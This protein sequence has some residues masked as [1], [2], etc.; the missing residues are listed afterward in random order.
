MTYFF[1][2]TPKTSGTTF[3][4]VLASDKNNRVGF[5][6]P[7][8]PEMDNFEMRI[9]EGPSYNLEKNPDWQ[10]YNFIGGHFTFG[11]HNTFK[12]EQFKYLGVVREPVSHFVSAYKALLRMPETYQNLLLPSDK[13]LENFISLEYLHNMQ[14]FFL[15]GMSIG[16]IKKDKVKAYNVVIENYEKYFAGIYP[17]HLFD[18]GLI[19]FKHKIG[20]VPQNYSSRN[21][22]RNNTNQVIKDETIEKIALAND[23]D[24]KLYDYFVKKFDTEFSAIP[25]ANL[26]V[27]LL[28][29]GNAINGIFASK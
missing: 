21:V 17:T 27:R 3:M 24:I 29:A 25:L 11:V 26:Q 1:V 28:K 14:T 8:R 6:Y 4:D 16:E 13:S 10:K 7:A 12:P 5:F 23:V 22:A 18:E 15:S 19:Y 9:K 2:H 20:I